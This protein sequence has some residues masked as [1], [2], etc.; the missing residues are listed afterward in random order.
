MLLEKRKKRNKI[1]KRIGIA[2]ATCA[3]I[4]TIC[5]IPWFMKLPQYN[6][7]MQLY[8]D[9]NYPEATWAFADLGNYRNSKEMEGKCELSWRKSL[10]EVYSSHGECFITPNGTVESM[11]FIDTTAI[12]D[13]DINSHGAAVSITASHFENPPY[14]L[15]E[16][17]YVQNSKDNNRMADDTEFHNIVKISD[18]FNSTNVA[19]RADGKMLFGTLEDPE[20]Y[21]DMW[22]KELEDWENIVD[23]DYTWFGNECA[24]TATVVGVK[25]DG[26]LRA[27]V[28]AKD[29]VNDKVIDEFSNIKDIISRFYDVKKIRVFADDDT[30]SIIALTKHNTMMVYLEK[31]FHEYPVEKAVDCVRRMEYQNG[32]ILQYPLYLKANGELVDLTT[33]H[34]LVKDI[35]K[36]DWWYAI[37][38]NG[39]LY[40]LNDLNSTKNIKVCVYDEWL[41]RIE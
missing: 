37:G 15:C 26:T 31:E 5:A 23:F 2:V 25:K 40:V 30:L 21:S 1:I 16:D 39:S 9:K 7:A 12:N 24:E 8:Y 34:S 3:V 4:G 38:R 10:A 17:G 32:V 13:F 14:I 11:E 19:L 41:E 27:V 18:Q 36:L 6:A 20:R 33:N 28:T 29:E 22:L 35:V